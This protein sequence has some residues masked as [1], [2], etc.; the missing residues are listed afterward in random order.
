MKSAAKYLPRLESQYDLKTPVKEGEGEGREGGRGGGVKGPVE[1]MGVA[2]RFSQEASDDVVPEAIQIIVGFA[3]WSDHAR[4]EIIRNREQI[5][6]YK[7]QLTLYLT[8]AS[9]SFVTPFQPIPLLPF[10]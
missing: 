6:L 1:M 2:F 10:S 4:K 3:T 8:P 9:M 7:T 5:P